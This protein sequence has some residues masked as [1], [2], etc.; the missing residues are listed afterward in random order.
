MSQKEEGRP[1]LNRREK[2]GLEIMITYVL[3]G[4]GLQD[5][6]VALAIREVKEDEA[7]Q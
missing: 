3:S 7:V 2:H 5:G 1:D 4:W 6:F